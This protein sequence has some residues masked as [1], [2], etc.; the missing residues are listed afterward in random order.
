[1]AGPHF[2]IFNATGV[3][4]PM[5]YQSGRPTPEPDLRRVPELTLTRGGNRQPVAHEMVVRLPANVFKP[6]AQAAQRRH[7][8]PDVLGQQIICGV[9]LKSSNYAACSLN[10]PIDDTSESALAGEV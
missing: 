9:V 8:K 1:M 2:W 3:S 4:T 7:L 5:A 6:L 10:P